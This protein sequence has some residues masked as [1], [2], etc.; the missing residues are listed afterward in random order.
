[1]YSCFLEI[2]DMKFKNRVTNFFYFKPIVDIH[3]LYLII[4]SVFVVAGAMFDNF[5]NI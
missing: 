1:M 5:K 4:V 3:T 2:I